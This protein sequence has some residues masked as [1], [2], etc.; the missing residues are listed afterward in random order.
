MLVVWCVCCWRPRPPINTDVCVEQ[1]GVLR[2]ALRADLCALVSSFSGCTGTASTLVHVRTHEECRFQIRLASLRA[3]ARSL[4]LF[5]SLSLQLILPS[6]LHTLDS[7]RPFLSG[8][9]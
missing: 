3:G 1:A 4:S 2:I 8:C 5:L 6:P 7:I 9:G